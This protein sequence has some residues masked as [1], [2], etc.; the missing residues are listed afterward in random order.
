[1]GDDGRGNEDG[2]PMGK[3][4]NQLQLLENKL[5]TATWIELTQRSY[6]APSKR[7]VQEIAVFVRPYLSTKIEGCSSKN[8]TFKVSR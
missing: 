3:V 4:N 1:M 8:S 6:C 2:G 5:A 7:P